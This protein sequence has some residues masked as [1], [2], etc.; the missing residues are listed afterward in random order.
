MITK[1]LQQTRCTCLRGHGFIISI[2]GRFL[3]YS[4]EIINVVSLYYLSIANMMLWYLRCKTS[5]RLVNHRL[6]NLME[7]QPKLFPQFPT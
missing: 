1:Q 6:L 2:Y 4:Y 5:L 3:L 7:T